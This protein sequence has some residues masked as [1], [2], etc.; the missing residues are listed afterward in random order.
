MLNERAAENIINQRRRIPKMK[1]TLVPE[2]GKNFID[3]EVSG[4]VI[5]FGDDEIRK[6]QEEGKG[7][8]GKD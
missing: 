4:N 1:V 6:P 3:Y 5:S 7:R 2:N 8:A